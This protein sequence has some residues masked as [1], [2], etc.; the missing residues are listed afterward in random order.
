MPRIAPKKFP[1]P[2]RALPFD[3]PPHFP[4]INPT[5]RPDRHNSTTKD[6]PQELNNGMAGTMEDQLLSLL[7]DT[8]LSAEAPRKQAEQHLEQAKANPAFPGSLAAIASHAS[9]SPQIRQ[10]A[11]LL[12]RTFVERNWSGESDDGPA[13]HIDDQVK[14]ALRRQMLELATSGDADRKIKSAASYV[15]IFSRDIGGIGRLANGEIATW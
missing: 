2:L 5:Q 13:V 7:A 11:L 1:S 6:I 3:T 14:E 8:Q 15:L 4:S 9:V 12:L 10:S